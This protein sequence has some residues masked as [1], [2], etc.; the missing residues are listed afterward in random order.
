MPGHI[1]AALIFALAL[2]AAPSALASGEPPHAEG[3]QALR[4]QA[5]GLYR[6]H[7]LAAATAVLNLAVRECP[8]DPFYRFMLANALYRSGQVRE[9]A[10]AYQAFLKDRDN[11]ADAHMS[12][13]FA[14]FELGDR[15]QAVD[16]WTQAVRLQPD[17]AVARAALA[18]GL[19]SMSD[20]DGAVVQY[21][22]AVSLDPV[23]ARP[24]NLGIDIRWKP[25][26]REIL[27]RVKER[28]SLE[29]DR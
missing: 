16:Q 10:A 4:L 12:L 15:K 3:C 22:R 21:R 24:E 18:V 20:T 11:H 26:V 17:S 28:T 13:G 2:T 27:T 19:Y 14:L 29:G 7:D 23:Y 5:T 6:Q 1:V 25:P 8:Q 9:S